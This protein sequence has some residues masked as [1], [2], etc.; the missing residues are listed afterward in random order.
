MRRKLKE[1]QGQRVMTYQ[2]LE[3]YVEGDK[4][5]YQPLNG[6]AW[7]GPAAVLCQRGSSVWLHSQGDIK[8]VAAC[9]VKPYKLVD[10][11]SGV[12]N[13]DE[14]KEKYMVMLED[15]LADMETL[16]AEME[17]DSTGAKYLTLENS[18]S[19]SEMCTFT[20][21]LPVSE[22]KRPKVVSA[23]RKEVENLMDYSTFEG[24]RD[25]GQET[26]RSRWVVTKKEKHDGQK[27]QYKDRLVA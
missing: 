3:K 24:V 12:E 18:V 17:K 6:N 27:L 19:F 15:G 7:L 25:E 16:H 21:E 5:W 10:R 2:H 13:E 14:T 22:H 20:V 4:V 9:R 8:K 26:I 23:K 11:E 1:C